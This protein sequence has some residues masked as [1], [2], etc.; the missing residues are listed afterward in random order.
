[1]KLDTDTLGL[2]YLPTNFHKNQR[3]MY[4]NIQSSHGSYGYKSKLPNLKGL[5]HFPEPHFDIHSLLFA[6]ESAGSCWRQSISQLGS[7]EQMAMVCFLSSCFVALS[8]VWSVG[9]HQV[10]VGGA[11]LWSELDSF[12]FLHE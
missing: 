5:S 12:T 8:C 3:F 4:V 6:A 10:T 2:V 11:F 1:M 9:M 7:F